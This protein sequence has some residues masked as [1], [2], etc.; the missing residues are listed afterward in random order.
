MRSDAKKALFLDLDGTLLTDDKKVPEG[1]R[2]ALERMLAEGHSVI[3]ATGRPLSSAVLEAGELGLT[4]EGCYLIAYNGGV[5]YD[6]ANHRVIFEKTI[7]LPLVFDVFDEANARGIHIQTYDDVATV[8]EP[9]CDN[10]VVR[11]YCG[12]IGMTHRVIDDIRHLEKEPVKMLLIDLNGR[13]YTEPMRQWVIEK[14]GDELDGF[15][16][17]GTYME[18]VRKGLDK[19]N[20]LEQMAELLGIP[21]ENTVA[22]GDAENDV[23]M[24]RA[25]HLGCAVANAVPECRAVADYVTERDNNH[26]AVAEIIEKFIL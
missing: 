19:G 25:A 16:S 18:I 17:S 24:I 14:H 1:N 12:R 26:S 11:Y 6:T 10:D 23:S 15:F 20:A 2:R 4:G 5:L 7:P 21:M 13:T 9:R 22:A 8:V 3:I